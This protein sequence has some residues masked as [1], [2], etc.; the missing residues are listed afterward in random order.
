[1]AE[2]PNNGTNPAEQPPTIDYKAEFEK[3]QA[4]NAHL[5]DTI[6]KTNSENADYKRQLKE[7]MSADEQAQQAQKE[8][9]EYYK[10]LER[11]NNLNKLSRNLSFIGDEE[12]LTKVSTLFAD[13]N[14]EGGIAEVSAY[15]KSSQENLAKEIKAE[16]LRQ[17]PQPHPSGDAG[18]AEPTKK[19]F[20][21]MSYEERIALKSKSPELYKKLSNQ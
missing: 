14:I 10:K 16:L 12:T 1:M 17:N 19:Q 7:K 6:S 18:G 5:R 11:E 3:M 8:R 15:W 9:E 4:E 13:G 2:E 20:D 21:R